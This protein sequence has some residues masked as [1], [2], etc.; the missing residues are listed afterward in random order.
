MGDW[1]KLRVEKLHNVRF[2]S[3]VGRMIGCEDG[4]DGT[5]NTN[6]R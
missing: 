5:C 1:R 4:V 6:F 3:L 2:S